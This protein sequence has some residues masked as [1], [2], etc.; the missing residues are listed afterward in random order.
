MGN[1]LEAMAKTDGMVH[2]GT[3]DHVS[4]TLECPVEPLATNG[5]WDAK[6]RRISWRPTIAPPKIESPLYCYAVWA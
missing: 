1:Q 5:Q 2:I 6:T 4:V 3:E